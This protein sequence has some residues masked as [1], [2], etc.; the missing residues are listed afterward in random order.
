MHFL[1]IAF[2]IQHVLQ[3]LFEFLLGLAGIAIAI[4]V[5]CIYIFLKFRNRFTMLLC[6]IVG[7]FTGYIGFSSIDNTGP[8]FSL[9]GIPFLICSLFS[10]L[11][12]VKDQLLD[13]E[14][15]EQNENTVE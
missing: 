10:I 7:G 5:L 14:E 6:V 8:G 13:K 4:N 15:K 1:S 2:E 11:I 12:P 9:I 3:G